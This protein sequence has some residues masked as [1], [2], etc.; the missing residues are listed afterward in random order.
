MGRVYGIRLLGLSDRNDL[1]GAS[2]RYCLLRSIGFP[3]PVRR[4]LVQADRR[5]DEWQIED[6]LVITLLGSLEEC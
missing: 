6:F 2:T 1:V 3:A 4:A 5:I